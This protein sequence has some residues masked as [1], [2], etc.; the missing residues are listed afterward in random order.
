MKKALIVDDS[1]SNR[2]V[3][4]AIVSEF[5]VAVV[6]AEDG[7]EAV[8]KFAAAKPEIVFID[9]IMPLK[10]GSDAIKQMKLVNPDFTAILMSSLINADEIKEIV[11]SCGAEEFLPKPISV[12]V[13][14]QL[15]KKYHI[16]D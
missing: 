13:I 4:G 11:E 1:E 14:S 15:L 5:N 7:D 10:N 9:Q 16:I 6:Y 3:I 2:L 8:D 12:S